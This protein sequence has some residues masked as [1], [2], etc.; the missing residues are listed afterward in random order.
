M[1]SCQTPFDS[2]EMGKGSRNKLSLSLTKELNVLVAIVLLV[3]L[4]FS[5]GNDGGE[6]SGEETMLDC[7]KSPETV[8]I[9]CRVLN[10]KLAECI[11][12]G[13]NIISV[14]ITQENENAE[15][16]CTSKS[17]IDMSFIG[18]QVLLNFYALKFMSKFGN[19]K[20]IV[21]NMIC[22]NSWMIIQTP[23]LFETLKMCSMKAHLFSPLAFSY[24]E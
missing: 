2:D 1:Y 7:I 3:N 16:N 21:N 9:E 12:K 24:L 20:F 11:D 6:K 14:P 8:M 15:I 18:F 23:L 22:Y 5:L 19:H 13:K 4:P 17:P 10:T